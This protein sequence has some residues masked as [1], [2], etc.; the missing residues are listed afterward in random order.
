MTLHEF[1]AW[2]ATP[3]GLGAFVVLLMW[4]VR[5]VWPSVQDDLAF[6]VST[7]LAAIVGI[8]AHYLLPWVDKL[9]EDIP[10]YIWPVLVWAWNYLLFRFGPT[11]KAN[12]RDVVQT[13]LAGLA[14]LKT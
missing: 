10:L 11:K 9:P 5:K 1:V 7:V 3:A 14:E 6:V 2:L 4:L 13:E 12:E 8:G